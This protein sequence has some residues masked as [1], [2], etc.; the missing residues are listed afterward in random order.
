[1]REHEAL[2]AGRPVR[3]GRTYSSTFGTL[4]GRVGECI[5]NRVRETQIARH[6]LEEAR[7]GLD[8]AS[9]A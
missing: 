6:G 4:G 7:A 8:M 5:P 9:L 2:V 3:A 1:M